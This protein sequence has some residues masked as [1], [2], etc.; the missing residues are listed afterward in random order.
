MVLRQLTDVQYYIIR[1][2]K[3]W[4]SST[5][6]LLFACHRYSIVN[7]L[8]GLYNLD[9]FNDWSMLDVYRVKVVSN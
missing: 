9:L 1:T 8:N 5:M 7:P 2:Y 6:K 4:L 3:E